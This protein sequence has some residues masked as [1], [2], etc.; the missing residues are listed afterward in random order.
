LTAGTLAAPSRHDGRPKDGTDEVK[1]F[2]QDN[3][4]SDWLVNGEFGKLDP[5]DR[6]LAYGDGL[7][8][9]MAARDGTVRWLEHHLDR[10]TAGCRRL[11]I[12][13][14]PLPLIRA[15]IARLL[16]ANGRRVVKLIVTRGP[17]MRGYRPPPEPAPTRLLRVAPWPDYPE[18]NATLGIRMKTCSLRLG[19]NPAL[20]GMKH[21]NRLEQVLAQME[22][23]A[24]PSCQEGLL[25]DGRG[26]IA[27]ATQSNLFAVRDG[28]VS[29][30]A[31]ERCGVRG[32]MRRAVLEACARLELAARETDMSLDDCYDAQEL[33]VTN[34]V[35]GIWP[36]RRLDAQQF[37]VGE[38]TRR[39]QMSLGYAG[40]A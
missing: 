3:A 27:G 8:E 18:Q 28:V 39:L 4:H 23:A 9:T 40:P 19:E 2:V 30:P 10:L 11:A 21:L 36:V 29:T 32:V 17:S 13:A 15:E 22:L 26:C 25:R 5:A 38:T 35:F 6:G 7:F 37:E 12:P 14:P 20:A 16:P 34:A 1:G 33:F 31:V 24:D